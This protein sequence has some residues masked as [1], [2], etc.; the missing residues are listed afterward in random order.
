M[1]R[2]KIYLG[3]DHAGFELKKKIKSWLKKKKIAFQDLGNL[4]FDPN[5]DYP[6]FAAK[7]AR[8]A[9]AAKSFGVLLCG[10]AEGMCIAANKISGAR[11]VAPCSLIAAKRARE[12]NNANILC[13]AGGKTLEP[14]PGLSFTQATKL[15]DTF[16]CVSFSK[17][18]RHMRR[19]N[20][21]KKLERGT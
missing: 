10:S 6:D 4:V 15:L 12:H 8:K 21:I 16:L 2:Q 1:T 18:E 9:V 3:S 5:D 19:L 7:V 17:E 20:K 13:L 11:A 14:M